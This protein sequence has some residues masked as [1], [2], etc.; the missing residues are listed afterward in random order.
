MLFEKG[1]QYNFKVMQHSQEIA[2]PIKEIYAYAVSFLLKRF[3][4]ELGYMCRGSIASAFLLCSRK[5][6]FEY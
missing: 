6:N 1:I 4:N 2:P 5:G 3:F